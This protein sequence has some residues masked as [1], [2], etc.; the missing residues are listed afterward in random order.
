MSRILKAGTKLVSAAD[1]RPGSNQSITMPGARVSLV[2]VSDTE[3]TME[4]PDTDESFVSLLLANAENFAL[5]VSGVPGKWSPVTGARM[6]NECVD[7]HNEIPGVAADQE[8]CEA[9][10]SVKAQGEDVFEGEQRRGIV[11]DRRVQVQPLNDAPERRVGVADRRV[12]VAKAS[13][14]KSAKKAA[15]KSA[16]KAS[17]KKAAKA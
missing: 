3:V 9:C 6:P 5:N 16:T 2:L 1:R 4:G 10:L 8:T 11:A 7:C 12:P 14:K 13:A 15:K 17:A